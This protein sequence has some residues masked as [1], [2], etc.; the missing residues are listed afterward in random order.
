MKEE[1]AKLQAKLP[2][3]RHYCHKHSDLDYFLGQH[4]PAGICSSEV[5]YFLWVGDGNLSVLPA[6]QLQRVDRCVFKEHY[7]VQA[8]YFPRRVSRMYV[9][10]YLFLLL[11]YSS[12]TYTII[13]FISKEYIKT[14][15]SYFLP[16]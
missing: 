2:Q 4:Q 13:V 9:T 8:T 10:I 1:I 15:L 3:C 6:L 11:V 14:T 5:L 12:V 16:V 7:F